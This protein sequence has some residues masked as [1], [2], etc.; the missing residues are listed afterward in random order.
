MLPVPQYQNHVYGYEQDKNIVQSNF[1]LVHFC[2]TKII[3]NSIY[4]NVAYIRPNI[5]SLWNPHKRETDVMF[6]VLK[7]NAFRRRIMSSKAVMLFRI[8]EMIAV[9]VL[10]FSGL[11]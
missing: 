7:K 2:H 4:P 1:N 9:I 11:S 10:D 5:V 8:V 3:Q 6:F